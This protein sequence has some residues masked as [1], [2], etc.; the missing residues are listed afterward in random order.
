MT[1][2]RGNIKELTCSNSNSVM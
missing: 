1:Y 2:T